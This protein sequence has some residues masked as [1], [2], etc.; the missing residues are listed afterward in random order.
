MVAP[1]VWLAWVSRLSPASAATVRTPGSFRSMPSTRSTTASVR[2]RDAPSGS[3]IAIAKKPLSSV[4]M[5][6]LGT[7]R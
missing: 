2:C 7:R 6:A 5:N 1:L 4:G 3:W